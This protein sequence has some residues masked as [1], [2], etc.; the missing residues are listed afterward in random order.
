MSGSRGT[1]GGG[2]CNIACGGV[3]TVGGGRENTSCGNCSTVGGGYKNI[4]L[5]TFS[6][7]SG[8]RCNIACAPCSTI[9]GGQI[10]TVSIYAGDST[11]GGGYCNTAS[12]C[13]STIGGGLRNTA[14]GTASSILGGQ[15][16]NTN[17]FSCSMIV[18]SD[19]TSNRA[20]TTFVNSLSIFNTPETGAT[21]SSI[22]VRDTDGLVKT[23]D[24]DNLLV[25][26]SEDTI[27]ETASIVIGSASM[28][29]DTSSVKLTTQGNND[30]MYYNQSGG[31]LFL[32]NAS[33]FSADVIRVRTD[34]GEGITYNAD[35]S[36]TFVDRSL[37]DKEYSDRQDNKLDE[38][39]IRTDEG[40]WTFDS[41]G[42]S[43]LLW[44]ADFSTDRTISIDNFDRFKRLK[45]FI[46][47]L[48]GINRNITI[49]S[50]E[51]TSGSYTAAQILTDGG[52][53][54]STLTVKGNSGLSINLYA[55]FE[56]TVPTYGPTGD[57]IGK[58]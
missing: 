50:R 36:S 11:I 58:Q 7:V 51:G 31:S 30:F 55:F 41:D 14:S 24:V 10:N 34:N 29:V 42:Y 27:N 28:M 56:P 6:N 22:L 19:I 8:G 52:D 43:A 33:T 48:G 44:Q 45:I 53:I 32:T 37:V 23:R 21:L 3:S 39:F 26:Y 57:V 54:L 49:E 17:S 25:Y 13:S 2:C 5:N 9:S 18:G 38:Y 12:G 40:S 46:I 15:C 4:A 47:N 1:I 16:N 35:Y 20:C